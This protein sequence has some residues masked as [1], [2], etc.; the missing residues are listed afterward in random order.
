[1]ETFNLTWVDGMGF[2]S[3]LI[4]L[5]GMF[6][7]TM[8][9]V[10]LSLVLGNIGFIAFGLLSGS[11]PTWATHLALLPLNTLRLYQVWHLIRTIRR[12]TTGGLHLEPLIPYMTE[13]KVAAGTVLFKKGDVPDRM[14][15][16]RAGAIHLE[17]IDRHF[18]P[19]D[20]LG[21]L[22]A[23]TP[24]GRRTAT[25]VADG[26]CELYTLTNEALLQIYY[27]NP[28]F[29]LFLIRTIVARLIQNWEDAERRAVPV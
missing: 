2:F 4:M 11:V 28:E 22:A 12:Q 29:G 18:G 21:E 9:P 13:T 1:M 14:I 7:R 16:V 15:I 17:E 10:R 19:G 24:D 5:F 26:D 6:R 25:A 27:Q 20:V 3:G 23:F 8:I